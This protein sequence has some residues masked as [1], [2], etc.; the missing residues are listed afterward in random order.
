MKS[1]ENG[2][3][4]GLAAGKSR[5]NGRYLQGFIDCLYRDPAGQ[6]HIID[7]KTNRVTAE[8]MP[9][10]A[11]KYEMQMLVYALAAETIL[12]HPPTE[13]ALCFLRPG[14]EFQFTWNDKTRKTGGGHGE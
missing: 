1:S 4:S 11:A 2:I 5:P 9:Q 6:W 8:T 12:K 10:E 13:L 7:Y 3:P 14:L